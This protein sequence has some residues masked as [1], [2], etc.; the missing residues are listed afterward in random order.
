MRTDYDE[1]SKNITK[2]SKWHRMA[3]QKNAGMGV[4]PRHCVD[5]VKTTTF[6]TTL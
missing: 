5:I 4:H 1:V 3:F 2:R 6:V